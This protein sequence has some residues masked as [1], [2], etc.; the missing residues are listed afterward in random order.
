MATIVYPWKLYFKRRELL[1]MGI[2][3]VLCNIATWFWLFLYIQPQQET[4]FLHY[5]ILFGVDYIGEWWRVF[6]IP[7]TGM[8]I[9]AVNTI[10]G[11]I[12]F[13]RDPLISQILQAVCLVCQVFLFV[14]AAL[15]VFLNV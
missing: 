2:L 3:T 4:V 12:V 9:A 11:W 10:L 5:N 13:Q 14:V 15:L 1:V 8:V 6:Y 7:L